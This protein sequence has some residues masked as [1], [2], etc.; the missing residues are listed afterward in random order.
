MCRNIKTLFNFEPP[1]TDE[2]IRRAALQFVRKVS[3]FNKPSKSNEA[4]FFAA[5]EE[6]AA[7][8]RNLLSSLETSAPPRSRE[9]EVKRRGHAPGGKRFLCT[10]GG[11]VPDVEIHLLNA[12]HFAPDEEMDALAM[13]IRRF[14]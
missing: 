13:L 6:I 2:E 9:V 14:L 10:F 7:A 4:A 12:G 5:V 3:G 1:V 8:C 11:E